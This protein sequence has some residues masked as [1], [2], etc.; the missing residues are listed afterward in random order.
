MTTNLSSHR[1]VIMGVVIFMAKRF[2][3]NNQSRRP[4]PDQILIVMICVAITRAWAAKHLIFTWWFC[5]HLQFSWSP[6]NLRGGTV[7]LWWAS[8]NFPY[9][10]PFHLQNHWF[11]DSQFH[12]RTW[13]LQA[14]IIL[15]LTLSLQDQAGLLPHQSH[16]NALWNVWHSDSILKEHENLR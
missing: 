1:C 4:R 9:F 13:L 7:D 5:L 8:I 12:I 15:D 11:V 2:Q 16:L 3:K 14:F 6:I 10:D